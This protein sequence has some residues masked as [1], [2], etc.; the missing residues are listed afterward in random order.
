MAS[1]ESILL[2]ARALSPAER[3]E[4]V[5]KL[6]AET[7]QD[8]EADESAVGRRGLAAWTESTCGESWEPYYPPGLRNNREAGS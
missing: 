6:L 2:D 4:L 3:A 5:T 1:L 8:V 7:A